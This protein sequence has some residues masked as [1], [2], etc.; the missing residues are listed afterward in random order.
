MDQKIYSIVK[1]KDN[2]IFLS[3]I[4]LNSTNQIAG[5]N[6]LEKKLSFYG[7]KLYHNSRKSSRGVGILISRKLNCTIT[8]Q[9]VDVD[10]N[11]LLLE[12]EI[13]GSKFT[14]GSIYG[15]NDDITPFYDRLKE[16]LKELQN[17]NVIVRGDWNAT[18]DNSV[19]NINIDVINM[20]NIPSK[21]RSDK[22]RLMCTELKLLD[23]Y[24][25][26]YPTRREYTFIPSAL[27][28]QNRSRLDFFIVSE[29]V[30]N[31]TVN[32]S[33]PH[34]LTSTIFDHKPVFLSTKRKKI[35]HK[36]T[37]ND[38]ILD[39]PDLQ[40]YVTIA[41][42]ETYIHHA[43][44][45]EK[46]SAERKQ[47]I[48]AAIGNI[49]DTLS[50]IRIAIGASIEVGHNNFNNNLA[51][52][53]IEGLR[54]EVRESI[55]DLPPLPFYENLDLEYNRDVFFETLS[56]SV[57]NITLG[58]QAWI[59]K[60]RNKLKATLTANI[61]NLKQ[62][63]NQN[64]VEILTLERRLSELTE[65]ELRN[66]LLKIKNFERLNNEKITPYFL[67][68]AKSSKPDA[69]LD[70]LKND[71]E[72]Q[73]NSDEDRD[74]YITRYYENIYKKPLNDPIATPDN[75]DNFLG[76]TANHPTVNNAKLTDAEKLSL[77]A[78]LNIQEFEKSMAE[79][80]LASAPGI[81]GISNKFIKHFWHL[82]WYPLLNYANHCFT[83]G[84]LTDSFRGAKIRLIPK[85][86]DPFK[87]KNWRPISLL[88]CFY[89][90]LSRVLTNRLRTYIDKITPVCQKGYSETRA[91]QEV[92]ISV[93][94]CLSKCNYRKTQGAILSLDI[95]KAF[96]T[97]SHTFLDSTLAFFNFGENYRRWIR[98]LATNR[99]ACVILNESKLSRIFSLE[100]GNAQGDTISPFLF[101]ICYQILLFKLEFDLQIL[102]ITDENALLDPLLPNPAQVPIQN[103][104]VYAYADDGNI[105]VS[106]DLASLS[107][108]KAIL[109][110][111]GTISGLVCNVDKT[112]L[113]QIGSDLPIPQEILDL[114]FNIVTEMTILGM[115]VGG[116]PEQNFLD[117]L[118]KV[119]NQR[120]FWSRFNLSLPGRINIA[121]S[122]MY[123]QINYLGCI[124]PLDVR[125]LQQLSI[126]IEDFVRGNLNIS[127]KRM[128]LSTEEGGLGLFVMCD[129]LDAQRCSWIKRAQRMDDLWKCTLFSKSYGNVVNLRA[130][131][132]NMLESPVLH[133]IA[134]SYERFFTKH[135]QWNEN[136]RSSFVY[137]NPALTINL[138]VRETADA[139]FFGDLINTHRAEI[140]RLKMKNIHNMGYIPWE[141][142]V[143][144][145]GIPI[146]ERKLT[147]LRGVFDTAVVK[148]SKANAEK[149][150]NTEL[151]TFINRFKKGSKSFRRVFRG[152]K[153]VA[154]S[155]NM[156]RF[157]ENTEIIIGLEL[158]EQLNCSWNISFLDNS[159]RT[160][161][162]R[163][164]NNALTYNH[165]I[166]HFADNIEPYC[167]FCM[168]TRNIVL[169]RD[170]AMHVFFSCPTTEE[171]NERYFS[172]IFGVQ[173]IVRRT[174]VFGFFHEANREDNMVLFIA[175]KI[176]QKYLWDNKLRKTLPDIEI[177]KNIVK[178]EIRILKKLSTKFR[179]LLNEC[180]LVSLK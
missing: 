71:L 130:E 4:R 41:V 123:S 3:D 92:L 55:D 133:G 76:E 109:N 46:L 169:E 138:R 154:I 50:R 48:L 47:V 67:K 65:S 126:L 159:L 165:V 37:V 101:I 132:F 17:N 172:W 100:R 11:I 45:N 1:N 122:M 114:G 146:S 33:I 158:S 168:I 106:M 87:L 35:S 8:R 75:I 13:N 51:E 91:C 44:L 135:T 180:S 104:R 175:T 177:L 10:D 59:F 147:G 89:K 22:L 90:I 25:I 24:R 161:I 36:Q 12:I 118:N 31:T 151:L 167:T 68:T 162:F 148:Y 149:L 29:S 141:N 94:D 54:A 62:S 56:S 129:F 63:F 108:I 30:M 61:K 9:F 43:V 38:I 110:E 32:C 150:D 15:P 99:T 83:T 19:V 69:S 6:D 176:M 85:K 58:H 136:F 42:Y 125:Q 178:S 53:E 72:Q 157:A 60:T 73:F 170:T 105:L 96:D 131:Q 21:N 111:F 52:M 156:V 86:G 40:F 34:S 127:R 163:L 88:N 128:T 173:K 139:D 179:E 93:S 142:F 16:G 102:G 70:N 97:L 171:L 78:P 140:Y 103:Y 160:F 20:V 143:R 117:I 49:D 39:D 28:L 77:E 26:F 23:P 64:T 137:N 120:L 164:H 112:C 113:M 174:E 166:T 115:N 79:S 80:N 18:W 155:N 27:G 66:E 95:S 134:Q 7:Y 81:D 82:F 153:N 121:K 124:L 57:K 116:A 119:N 144:D 5:L 74:E 84:T 14:I 98:I 145:T 152:E 2:I 107:R